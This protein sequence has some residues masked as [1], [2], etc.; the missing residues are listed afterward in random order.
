MEE[1]DGE[2]RNTGRIVAV[3]HAAVVAGCNLCKKSTEQEGV[4]F[5]QG[6]VLVER[7]AIGR[8]NIFECKPFEVIGLAIV[9]RLSRV[10]HVDDFPTDDRAKVGNFITTKNENETSE[11]NK[12]VNVANRNGLIKDY[13]NVYYNFESS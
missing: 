4:E 1:L 3:Q 12:K 9:F 13:E 2:G 6:P 8:N 10:L 11:T 5:D 7:L